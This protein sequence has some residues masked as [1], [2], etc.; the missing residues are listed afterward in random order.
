MDVC[1][2]FFDDVKVCLVPV[3]FEDINDH[4]DDVDDVA[5]APW[6]TSLEIQRANIAWIDAHTSDQDA[7]PRM[8]QLEFKVPGLPEG[9]TIEA[10][11]FVEYKRP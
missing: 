6:D 9:L 1:F 4:A 11:L 8:Q 2:Q 10:K 3:E 5:I 7:A